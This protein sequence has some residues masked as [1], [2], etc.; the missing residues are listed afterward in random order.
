M[1]VNL[2]APPVMPGT[3]APQSLNRMERVDANV[4]ATQKGSISACYAIS[5]LPRV[6]IWVFPAFAL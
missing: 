1:T 2:D 3:D 4:E 6:S 5:G